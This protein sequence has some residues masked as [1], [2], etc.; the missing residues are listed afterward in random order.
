MTVA[1]DITADGRVDFYSASNEKGAPASHLMNR[2]YGSFLLPEKY[3]AGL[4]PAEILTR[5]AWGVA[6]GD[7]TGD[8]ANDPVVRGLDGAL[9]LAV[10][11]T[12]T[13][14]KPTSEPGTLADE[15]KQIQ[16]RQLTVRLRGNLGALGARID[17]KNASG[18]LVG[19]RTLGGNVGVGCAGPLEIVFSARE[20]GSHSVEVRF[21]DG[22]TISQ[23]AD[24]SESSPRH[25]VTVIEH[26]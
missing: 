22:S 12:L 17:L 4:M 7:V 24:L 2:G 6:T 1:E 23:P 19:R 15:R 11:E 16:S 18:I 5:S 21:F 10:N 25:Q 20:P 26:P 3:A 14:R 8:G 9:W 13:D